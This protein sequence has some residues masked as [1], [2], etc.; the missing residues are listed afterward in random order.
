MTIDTECLNYY[1]TGKCDDCYTFA[2]QGVA[3]V[4]V[5]IFRILVNKLQGLPPTT[6]CVLALP[7]TRSQ[8]YSTTLTK[9]STR[10]IIDF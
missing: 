1:V 9:M 10:I 7:Y 5:I 8:L 4:G 2:C 3:T 6:R